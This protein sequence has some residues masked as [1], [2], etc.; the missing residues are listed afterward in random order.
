M[1]SET[2]G[3][4]RGIRSFAIRSGRMTKAQ[5]QAW[6]EHWPSKGLTTSDSLLDYRAVFGNP[7]PVVMEIGFGMGGSLV[8]MARS[9]PEL[10][11]IGIEVHR[12]GVG[13]LL[14]KASEVALKNLRVFCNDANEVI[15]RAIPDASLARVQLYFPDPWHKTRHNKRRLVQPEF[16][17]G[18]RQKLQIGGVFHMATDWKPYAE[19]MMKVMD[20][21]VGYQNQSGEGCFAERPEYRPITKFETRGQALGHGV[22]DLL[23][24]RVE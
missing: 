6:D 21:S 10:N 9:A 15:A 13:A 11:F 5:R 23:Y 3:R 20:Q 12:P 24:Q 19:H 2:E 14:V 17:Q 1:N 16:V 8:E 4:K 18:I 7:N 22:W